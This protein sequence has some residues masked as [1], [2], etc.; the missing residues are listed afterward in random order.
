MRSVLRNC[1]LGFSLD[2]QIEIM[3]RTAQLKSIPESV[4]A[5]IEAQLSAELSALGDVQRRDLNGIDSATQLLKFMDTEKSE[6]LLEELADI[7]EDL[8]SQVRKAMFTFEDLKRLD[9][10][11][12]Q[13]LLKEIQSDQLVLSLKTA[14][15]EIVR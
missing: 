7:D 10:R 12:M 9:S 11:G 4:V 13:Q 2:D 3:R 14:S 1:S 5:D 8:A 15:E 6:A